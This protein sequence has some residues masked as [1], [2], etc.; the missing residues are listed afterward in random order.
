VASATS[1]PTSSRNFLIDASSYV[2]SA[3]PEGRVH[4]AG[5]LTI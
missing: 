2:A 3:P 5:A 1:A 4:P